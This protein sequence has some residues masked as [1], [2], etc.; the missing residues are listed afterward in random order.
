MINYDKGCRN[1][2]GYEDRVEAFEFGNGEVISNRCEGSFD[3]VHGLQETA[4]EELQKR[5]SRQREEAAQTKNLEVNC[6]SEMR[7]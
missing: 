1:V 3:D 6:G 4:K 5:K 2:K 7:H